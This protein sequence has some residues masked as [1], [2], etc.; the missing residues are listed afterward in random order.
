MTRLLACFDESRV[1]DQVAGITA[2]AIGG[3]VAP[4]EQ[5]T[6]FKQEWKRAL[7]RYKIDD[8][9]MTD[10]ENYQK[11]FKDW[12]QEL[13]LECIKGLVKII[14]GNCLIGVGASLI[15]NDY[16]ALRSGLDGEHLPDDDP[17]YLCLQHC[18]FLLTK[19]IPLAVGEIEFVFD[20]SPKYKGEASNLY[21]LLRKHG[22]A[23]KRDSLGSLSFLQAKNFL[24]L[25]AADVLAYEVCKDALHRTTGS[26]PV[27]KSAVMLA[28]GAITSNYERF[29]GGHY[30]KAKLEEFIQEEKEAKRQQRSLDA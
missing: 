6:K 15:V 10:F 17:Y 14:R 2:F 7:T 25:Q 29:Y 5:W 11:Q 21:Q 9:H 24:P 13:H 8:F 28:A 26:R 20:D 1:P 22:S 30:D 3:Y 18:L 16:A 23:V 27:R 19:K 4:V 12:S